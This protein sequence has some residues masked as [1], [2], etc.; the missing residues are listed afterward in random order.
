VTPAE[1]PPVDARDIDWRRYDQ[2][3]AQGHSGRQI[4]QALGVAESTLRGAL[5]RRQAQNSIPVQR[6]V[7]D[8]AGNPTMHGAGAVHDSA[9]QT[10]MHGAVQVHNSAEVPIPAAVAEELR[11]L[12]AAI[13]ALR[14]DMHRPVQATVQ[15]LPEPLFEDPADNATE[16]WNLYLKH[17]LR[18]RIEALAQ[19]R[20]VA[21]SRVVQ[22]ILW[23]ALTDH[24]PAPPYPAYATTRPGAYPW[25]IDGR[26]GTP[27]RKPAYPWPPSP[28]PAPGLSS[29][30]WTRISGRRRTA[31][32]R[33][34][35]APCGAARAPGR[36][37]PGRRGRP[38]THRSIYRCL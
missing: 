13:D 30:C 8:G 34:A 19:A 24:H 29:R 2:L 37:D 5:K 10:T 14:A 3:K 4:A 27:P 18:V 22:E 36:G 31:D 28:R 17:G 20:G 11:R 38:H 7:Q 26:G 21:P 9:V 12:W 1:D 25:P 33:G 32:G 16:R 15:S 35:R 23:Q 6:T